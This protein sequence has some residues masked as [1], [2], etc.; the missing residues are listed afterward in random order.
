MTASRRARSCID[1]EK[2]PVKKESAAALSFFYREMGW[3]FPYRCTISLKIDILIRENLLL[4]L[5]F[6][7]FY[8]EISGNEGG[9]RACVHLITP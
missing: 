8:A 4:E 1:T 5:D 9:I 3:S 2:N 6:P 7:L